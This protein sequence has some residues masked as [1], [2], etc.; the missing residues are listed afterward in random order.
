MATLEEELY[1]AFDGL[2]LYGC[3]IKRGLGKKKG[4]NSTE[5]FWDQRFL[6][7]WIAKSIEE[8]RIFE[9]KKS[10]MKRPW[11]RIARVIRRILER[12]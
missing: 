4:E 11:M 6:A 1:E 7:K 3:R 12:T 5:F 10:R 2:R 8:R 9:A